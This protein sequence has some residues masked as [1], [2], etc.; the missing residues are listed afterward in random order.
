MTVPSLLPEKHKGAHAELVAC[1]W[2]LGQGYEVYRNVSQHGAI[3]VIAIKDG[4]PL[5]LDIKSG[6]GAGKPG[7][8]QEQAALGVI[9]LIVDENGQCHIDT[10][11][12]VKGNGS[13]ARPCQRCGKVFIP[14]EWARYCS[15]FCRDRARAQRIKRASLAWE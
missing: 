6:L 7:I 2:L 12:R 9:A 15:K 10:L 5:F 14:R 13:K 4:V 11:P 3:D 8:S 1:V